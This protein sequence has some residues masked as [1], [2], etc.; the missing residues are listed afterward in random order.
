MPN[1]GAD[2]FR[3]YCA[4]RANQEPSHKDAHRGGGCQVNGVVLQGCLA[5]KK[6]THPRTLQKAYMYAQ[7]PTVVPGG[8]GGFL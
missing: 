2:R 3:V 5:H 6:P 4:T 1:L 8:G 7:G